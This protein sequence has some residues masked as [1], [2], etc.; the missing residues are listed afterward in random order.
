MKGHETTAVF[1]GQLD[2]TRTQMQWWYQEQHS[3]DKL[4]QD[5]QSVC[6]SEQ[7]DR[8]IAKHL[9]LSTQYHLAHVEWYALPLTSLLLACSQTHTLSARS[10][11]RWCACA[12]SRAFSLAVSLACWLAHSPSLYSFHPPCLIFLVFSTCSLSLSL[13][14][15]FAFTR[16]TC[17]S[18]C[19]SLSVPCSL[20]LSCSVSF[21][22]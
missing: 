17:V 1:V 10:L 5:G 2:A 19:L 7:I 16:Y 12:L 9:H 13:S 22:Q 14:Y 15:L 3:V 11:V 20:S 18:P 21:I 6:T 8:L 4:L